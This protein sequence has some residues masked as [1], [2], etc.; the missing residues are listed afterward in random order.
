MS[1]SP[2]EVQWLDA[3]AQAELVRNGEVSTAELVDAALE[4]IDR[5]NPTLN[6]VIHR[7]D[8][9]ARAT[10]PA[11]GPFR[12]VPFL[13]K[14][15]V[16][17]SA[18]HP[19]HCGM[20]ALK[21]AAHTESADSEMVRRIRAAGF[22]LVGKTNLPELAAMVTTE[23]LAYG[24]SRN[25]WDTDRSTGGSSGGAGA[26]VASGMVAVAHGNDMG[27]SIR[28]PSAWCGLVGLKPTRARTSLA[29]SLGEFWGPLTHEHVLTRSVRDTAACLDA[30]A[31]PAPG[32]PYTAPP[33][34]RPWRDEVGADVG[35]LRIAYRPDADDADAVAALENTATL[36]E[37]LGHHVELTAMPA[38]EDPDLSAGF[39]AIVCAAIARDLDRWGERIGRTL[40]MDDVEPATWMM[41][42]LGHSTTATNYI[43]AYEAL[44]CSARRIAGA[45]HGDDAID[46][47]MTAT[48][49]E[50][51]IALGQVGP[52]ADPMQAM[53]KVGQLVRFTMPF[54]ATGQPAISLPLHWTESGLPVGVQ[55]VAA[56]GR[57][58]VLI[59]LASQLEA[60]RPWTDRRPPVN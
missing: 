41:A 48:V 17:H 10:V 29:P 13:L 32:D 25:P 51:P 60:A 47:L 45:W 15:A 18:G 59:R 31:G 55:F 30:L 16:A 57:E 36:L 24:P 35:R 20:R 23:P 40:T 26:A 27:G 39:G 49:P 52:A 37:Q 7:F 50:P 53:A 3:T 9:E 11:E 5:L 46:V 8:D 6:A 34:L 1:V 22:V 19:F 56:S 33:P 14:D 2:A 12:G 38:L 58:D 43:S 21:A 54:N 44:Q 4:T 28:V 42:T